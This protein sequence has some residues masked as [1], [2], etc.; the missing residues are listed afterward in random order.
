MQRLTLVGRA[1]KA[2]GLGGWGAVVL[3]GLAS[4]GQR[5]NTTEQANKGFKLIP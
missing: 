1:W 2:D 5:D 4:R 3:E